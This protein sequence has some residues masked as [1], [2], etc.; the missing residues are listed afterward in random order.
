M[1][2]DVRNSYHVAN[3]RAQRRAA[4]PVRATTLVLAAVGALTASSPVASSAITADHGTT[5]GV[6]ASALTRASGIGISS[7]LQD[8]RTLA[9]S[10]DSQRERLRDAAAEGLQAAAERQA[11][12]RNA[13]LVALA[14]SAEKQAGLIAQ[15]AWQLPVSRGAYRLTSRFG[16]CSGLWS[17]CHTGLDFAAP[18]GT[19]IQAVAD[20][21]VTE[22][23]SAGAYGNRTIITLEDGT[24]LWFCHQTSYSVTS[25]QKVRAGE[26]I[27]AVGSTGNVTGPHV[28]VEVRPG[29][30]D[31]VDP[32]AALV[33]H[34]LRP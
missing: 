7:R 30:G 31:P 11:G 21:T 32:Y 29:A 33:V 18:S 4:R 5:Y 3:H 23:G 17:Q 24:E 20:G 34:G 12:E 27:G 9:V 10:R 22:V 14:A 19:P 28:H 1:P 2:P 25:G 6:H 8:R 13:A 26:V 16:D 15:D